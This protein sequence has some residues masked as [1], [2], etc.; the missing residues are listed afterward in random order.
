MNKKYLTFTLFVP[1][2]ALACTENLP[3]SEQKNNNVIKQPNILLITADDL[4]KNLSC[5]GDDVIQTPNIDGLARR[6]IIFDNGYVTQSSS[7]PSRSSILTGLYP[8]SNG[9]IGLS[10]HGFMITRN[11]ID[12]IPSYLKMKG[13]KNGIIGKLHVSPAKIFPFN[14]AKQDVH[15]TRDMELVVERSEE[16]IR[17]SGEKPFFLYLNYFDP[18][19][20]LLE[21]V[22][23]RPQ[24]V[25]K[26]EDVHPFNFQG[27]DDSKQLQ[28]IADYYNCVKRLDDGIGMLIEKLEVLN[29]LEN[30]IIIFVGDNGA[31]FVRG[32][33]ACYESSVNVP[34]FI[35]WPQQI[36]ENIRSN[37]LVSTVDIFPTIIDVLGDNIPNNV[38]GKSLLPIFK[39][40]VEKIRSN[41]FTE[42]NYHGKML[43][44]FYPR[45]TI[46]NE[47]YKLILNLA[48]KHIKNGL[49][50]VDGDISFNMSQQSKYK[51]SW[52]NE[53]YNRLQS[54]PEIEFF[55]L[56]KDPY[57]KN[58][59]SE[60]KEYKEIIEAMREKLEMWMV[61]TNDPFLTEEAILNE[62]KMLN[63]T[64]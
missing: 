28:R 22:N 42:F 4:G 59:L 46:R 18:H 37:A 15:E 3:Q 11:D 7:S 1:G 53:V 38:Q 36:K 39:G 43:N 52:V 35:S 29:V 32:K 27:V 64:H 61:D 63:E 10:N 19:A 24:K 6:G 30:T 54:P 20:P 13:Y 58:N 26:S 9:H 51:D 23:N 48:T 56:S 5:Y 12:N 33:G 45:R 2:V 50:S 57:E 25:V 41:L 21:Q 8:H 31:P 14:Y 47:Q 16:F 49:T 62:I 55:D 60:K 40:D 17:K 34:F 44:H